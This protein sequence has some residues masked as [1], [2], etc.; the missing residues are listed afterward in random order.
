MEMKSLIDKIFQK[1]REK[2]LND[3]EVYYSAGSSLTLKV[4]QKELETYNLSESEGLSLRG[5]YKGKMGYSYTEKVDETSI[6]QLVRDVLENAV[7]IDSDD[8]EFIFEGSKEYIKVDS[9][10]PALSNVSEEKKIEFVKSLEE[11]AFKLDK[12]IES[13]EVCV[14]GDGYGEIIMSNTKG[15]FLQ[16]KSN[17]AYTYI[18]VVAKEGEDIKTGMAYRTGNDFNK[19]NARDIAKEAVDEALALLGAK[20][21]K[22][23]D[24]NVIIRNSAAAD[25][26]EAFTGIFSAEAV[27]KNLSLLKGKLNEKIASDKFTLI[28]DPYMESGLASKSF[29][30]EGVACKYKKVVDKGVLKTYF[31]NLKTAKKDGVETTGNASKG[32]YK[33]SLGISPSNFYVEKGERRLNEMITDINKGILITELQGLHSGLNTVSGDFSLAALGFLIENGKI[34]RPVEQITVA[35]NYFEMLKNIEETGSDLKFG[36]PGGSY[37]GSPSLKIKKLSIAG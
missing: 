14:Y 17:I 7:I 24:Y 3:M 25:L 28:D 6:D 31:H 27:Q 21:V 4:F 20:S 18:V 2:G 9:F 32:S 15:L 23:G 35:G 8:E 36:L 30:G 22:S 29:D 37:I 12:R 16:D 33:S 5:V 10:N 26:L 34:S 19:F 13:V 11:E 1:G